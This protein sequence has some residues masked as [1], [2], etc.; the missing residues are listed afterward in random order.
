MSVVHMQITESDGIQW[1]NK[2]TQNKIRDSMFQVETSFQSY[3]RHTRF[4]PFSIHHHVL[5]F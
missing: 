2:G 5:S 3:R 4:H 1:R